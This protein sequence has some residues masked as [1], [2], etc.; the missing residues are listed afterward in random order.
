MYNIV[1]IWV[2]G[3]MATCPPPKDFKSLIDYTA[4]QAHHLHK[5]FKSLQSLQSL[6]TGLRSKEALETFKIL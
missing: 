3:G 6:S 4:C 1:Y 2:W 5:D